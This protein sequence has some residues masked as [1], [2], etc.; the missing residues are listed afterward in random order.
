MTRRLSVDRKGVWHVNFEDF[1]NEEQIWYLSQ[2]EADILKRFF[3]SFVFEQWNWAA[4]CEK[5]P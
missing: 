2:F 5:A 3:S 1:T 4:G